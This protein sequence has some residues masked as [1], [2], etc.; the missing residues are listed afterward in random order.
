MFTISGDRLRA[1]VP[2]ADAI[3]AVRDAFIALAQGKVDQPKRLSMADGSLLAMI[4][5]VEGG[6]AV[7]KL[8]SVREGNR[9]L[10][11]PTLQVLVIWFSSVTGEPMAIID[12]AELTALRTGAASGLATDLFANPDASVLTMIGAGA[13]AA[14][15]IRAIL[16]VR[17]VVDVRVVSR[18]DKSSAAFVESIRPEFPNVRF[19][20]CREP[21]EALQGAQI[22]CTATTATSPVFDESDLPRGC[23]INAVGAFRPTMCEIPPGVLAR[24]SVIAV[25]HIPAALAEAGD[26]I[27]AINGGYIAP[28]DLVEIGSLLQSSM[29]REVGSVTV[30]K[31]VGVAVQDWAI[32]AIAV[33]RAA[34]AEVQ[35]QH[36]VHAVGEGDC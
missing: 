34:R 4:A 18:H 27:Q 20:A 7:A 16:T 14:D 32:A 12:G 25:D 21:A 23:H 11:L 31:S 24:A 33:D 5:R 13:L 9:D 6:G 26:L 17:P 29:A 36:G 30:F 15:Q 28:S 1:A 35:K 3:N 2:M 22:L 10:G 8:V 19:K